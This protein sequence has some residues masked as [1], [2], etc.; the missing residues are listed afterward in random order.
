MKH[1]IDYRTGKLIQNDDFAE[2]VWNHS[3]MTV[4]FR[5]IGIDPVKCL[6]DDGVIYWFDFD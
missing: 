1:P 3:M 6:C 2:W 5:W 4:I